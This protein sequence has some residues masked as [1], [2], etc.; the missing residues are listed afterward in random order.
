M[1]LIGRHGGEAGKESPPLHPS[2]TGHTSIGQAR[3]ARRRSS[4]YEDEPSM[5]HLDFGDDNDETDSQDNSGRG[6]LHASA[7]SFDHALQ[8]TNVGRKVICDLRASILSGPGFQIE[9]EES[10]ADLTTK[11]GEA[12]EPAMPSDRKDVAR[13]KTS[14]VSDVSSLDSY[15]SPVFRVGKER[16]GSFSSLDSLASPTHEEND[17]AL[18]RKKGETPNHDRLAENAPQGT[19]A[20][21]VCGNLH[22][23][24]GDSDELSSR[25]SV[26]SQPLTPDR[27]TSHRLERRSSRDS[28][29][30][31]ADL[32]GDNNAN[33]FRA[34]G[35]AHDV[36]LHLE[37]STK[38]LHTSYS[39]DGID[40]ID[41]NATNEGREDFDYAMTAYTNAVKYGHF[42]FESDTAFD[43]SAAWEGDDEV[44]VARAYM[45]LGFAR[46]IKG[47]PESSLDAYTKAL[48]VCEEDDPMNASIQYTIG[49]V[50]IE[51]QRPMKAVAHFTKALQL[52]K[53]RD[54]ASDGGVR[55]SIL[56]TEGM[57]FSVLGEANRALDCFQKATITFQSSN[58]SCALN[59]KFAGVMHELG[60]ILSQQGQ[61]EASATCFN[62][63]LEIRKALLGDSF[64]VARTHYSL[65]VTTAALELHSNSDVTSSGH[66]EE[67]LRICQGGDEHVQSASAIIIHALGVL[68]ERRGDFHAASV[69]FVKELKMRKRLFGEGELVFDVPVTGIF[70]FGRTLTSLLFTSFL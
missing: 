1:G 52:F 44:L 21:I 27:R 28:S 66:L 61:Y 11:E 40:L 18:E 13:R 67:A 36:A 64:L 4:T 45:G 60:S 63:G 14:R 10:P 34:S 53:Q 42:D 51:M 29:L 23:S 16:S 15:A 59:L 69:W 19:D 48:N 25:G 41:P 8:K 43:E 33:P 22:R 37:H 39:S 70:F 31:F 30:S 32:D 20:P 50:L 65:G 49:T 6:A 56:S 55:E 57:L 12:P 46:Q 68:Y 2:P 35:L 3:L 7:S 5:D 62:F 58:L 17:Q 47:E 9:A 54:P 26:S 24:P 38:S